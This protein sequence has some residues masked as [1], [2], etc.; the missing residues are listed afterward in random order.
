MG[1]GSPKNNWILCQTSQLIL[2]NIY[3]TTICY[4]VFLCH[5]AHLIMKPSFTTHTLNYI[6]SSVLSSCILCYQYL[7]G[8]SSSLNLIVS[9]CPNVDW[10]HSLLRLLFS[11]LR[12]HRLPFLTSFVLVFFTQSSYFIHSEVVSMLSMLFCL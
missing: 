6:K 9:F 5:W 4:N 12:P 1:E 10:F 8:S 2:I 11:I 7:E 3:I